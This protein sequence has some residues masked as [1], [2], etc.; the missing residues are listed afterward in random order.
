MN[1]S[2]EKLKKYA[3]QGFIKGLVVT[4]LVGEPRDISPNSALRLRLGRLLWGSKTGLV[5]GGKSIELQDEIFY[6]IADRKVDGGASIQAFQNL[7]RVEIAV[8]NKS[9]L[10]KVMIVWF[11]ISAFVLVVYG[12]MH[13]GSHLYAQYQQPVQQYRPY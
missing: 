3:G 2:I 13:G 10:K 1:E 6:E 5:S 7:Q 8:S 9:D 12:W 4:A 11:L